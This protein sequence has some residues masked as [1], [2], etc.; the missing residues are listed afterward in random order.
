MPVEASPLLAALE[1]RPRYEAWKRALT[2]R[3]D[4]LRARM[5]ELESGGRIAAVPQT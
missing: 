5:L 4:A 3:R 2:A 1:G